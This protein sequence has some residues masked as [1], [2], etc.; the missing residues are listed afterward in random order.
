MASS[1]LELAHAGPDRPKPGLAAFGAL[2]SSPTLSVGLASNSADEK[3]QGILSRPIKKSFGGQAPVN[4][5]V[6]PS[7]RRPLPRRDSRE[8]AFVEPRI[9]QEVAFIHLVLRSSVDLIF[10]SSRGPPKE[11]GARFRA[12]QKVNASWGYL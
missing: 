12:F 9:P 1:R 5:V 3:L 2:G 10:A 4:A 7:A 11:F 8:K 6:P